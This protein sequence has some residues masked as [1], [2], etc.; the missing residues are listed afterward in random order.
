MAALSASAS[1]DDVP[2]YLSLDS[3]L[4]TLS[5]QRQLQRLRELLGEATLAAYAE[6]PEVASDV[7][8]LRYLRGRDHDVDDAARVF[9]AHLALRKE[10]DLDAV[11]ARVLEASRNDSYSHADFDEGPFCYKHMPVVYNAGQS[12][13]GHVYCYIP[14]GRQDSRPIWN[15][16]GGFEKFFQFC[17]DEWVARDLGVELY[18][19]R[20]RFRFVHCKFS[21]RLTRFAI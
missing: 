13:E 2:D 6:M 3:P 10:H 8:L 17:I 9:R 19:R 18:S 7:A 11:R 21:S 4:A 20:P 5:E 14:I 15:A 16:A 1:D 12:R